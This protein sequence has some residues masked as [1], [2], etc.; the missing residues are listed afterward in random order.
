VAGDIRGGRLETDAYLVAV[1]LGTRSGM[2]E[3]SLEWLRK[4]VELCRSDP[5][6]TPEQRKEHLRRLRDEDESLSAIRDDPRFREI[7]D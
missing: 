3:E 2:L 5:N 1:R 6:L 4:H 7:F